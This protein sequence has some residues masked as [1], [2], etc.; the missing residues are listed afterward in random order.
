V[1]KFVADSSTAT[2][3]AYAAPAAGALTK[4]STTTFSNV[5]TQDIDSVFTSTYNTYVIAVSAF[6]VT[7]A[8]ALHLQFRHSTNTKAAGYFGCIQNYSYIG[9]ESYI[10]TNDGTFCLLCKSLGAVA[11]PSTLVANVYFGAGGGISG[12]PQIYGQFFE[13]HNGEGGQFQ[14]DSDESEIYTGFRLKSSSSNITGT[15]V[16]YGLEK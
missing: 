10:G 16:V 9:T 6:A 7:A 11:K 8:N 5:A 2:G 3:L 15:V 1:P 14:Y 13:S 12:R 4:I